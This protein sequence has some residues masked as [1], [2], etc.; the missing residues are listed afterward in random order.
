MLVDPLF[1][2]LE[3]Y[4]CRSAGCTLGITAALLQQMA[5]IA[6]LSTGVNGRSSRVT[7][8]LSIS[9]VSW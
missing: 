8:C 7:Q 5:G 4:L 6:V 1:D 3:P 2:D 9:L